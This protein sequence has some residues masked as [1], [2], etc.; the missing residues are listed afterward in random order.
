MQNPPQTITR[1]HLLGQAL[2]GAL[3]LSAGS[4]LGSLVGC[5]GSGGTRFGG[6]TQSVSS[7]WVSTTLDAIS[8]VRPGPPMTAR[9]LALV[10][11]A[12]YDAWA[13]YDDVAYSTLNG[14]RLRRPQ[15]ERNEANKNAA[16]SYAAYRLLVNLYP[17][18]TARFEAK[19][20]AL[21]FDPA[22]TTVDPATPAGVGNRVAQDLIESRLNDGSNQANGYA[23]TTGYTPVNTP[24]LVTDPSR[25]QPLRFAN[26]NAPGYIAP[27]WGNVVP[28][29]LSAPSM[30]RPSA[31]PAYGSPAYLDQ[32][33]EVLGVLEHLDDRGK[34]IA[35]YW[36]DGPGS[37]L[38][39]GHWQ[40]FGQFVSN[41]DGHTIDQDVPMYFMLG[42][43][44]M[45]A[46]IACWECKRFYESSRPITAIRTLKSGQAVASFIGPNQGVLSAPGEQWMPYQSPNF[47]TPPFPEYTSGHSTFSAAA[48]EVLKR[49][50]GSDDFGHSVTFAPGWSTFESGVPAQSMSL[51]WDTF[52]EAA[53]EAG[54]SRIYGGIHFRAGDLGGRHCG[55]QVGAMVHDMCMSYLTGS[56]ASRIP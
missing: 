32:L 5:G 7:Q 38:P 45:D 44:V 26:G 48:A 31:P 52:S 3:L 4:T 9:A 10:A 46:G 21:G 56:S 13:C 6:R 40:L 8:A 14:G 29:A 1:R 18:Q 22:I 24:D 54:I 51:S 36:A 50:T 17:T 39:P 33:E 43:A 53:D 12:A 49:L 23:D 28:F 16:V 11:T 47:I 25:W 42:N 41:R 20:V 35:E 30:V 27:H 15:A 2:R 55:R 37:V 19:L 34:V